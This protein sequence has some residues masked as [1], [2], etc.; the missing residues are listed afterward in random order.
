[1][2]AP[3]IFNNIILGQFVL[4]GVP[5]KVYASGRFLTLTDAD[6]IEDPTIGFGMDENGAMVQ[7]SYP[8][9]EF[10][11]VHGNRVDI[12]T[13]NK[14]METLHS[15][16]DAPAAKEPENEEDPKDEEE[17][18]EAKSGPSMSD[19]Y[20]PGGKDM[21]LKNLIKEHSLGTL[22][23]EKLIKM[24]YNP[25]AEISQ[26]EADAEQLAI[27]AM[28]DAGDAKIKAAKEKEKELKKK[29]IDD[30]IVSTGMSAGQEYTFGTGDI[31]NNKDVSCNHHGSKGF[32]IQLS[33]DDVKYSVTNGGDG[34]SYKPG[35]VL[36]KR[37]DQ[38]EKI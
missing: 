4:T 28:A 26:D 33:A 21:K 7:F 36:T 35:D 8:E 1:M 37:K 34:T 38:L 31:V 9:V 27:D 30:G 10:I 14:G 11:S 29:P 12:A 23:S 20:N 24:K 5:V 13:Y 19:H 18:G 17:G 22:P 6:D 3:K 2:P 15:G 25:L 16:D 32:V